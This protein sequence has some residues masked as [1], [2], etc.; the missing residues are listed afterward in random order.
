MDVI[1]TPVASATP[2][3]ATL[4]QARKQYVSVVGSE[5]GAGKIYAQFLINEFGIEWIEAKHDAPGAE[6]DKFRAERGL[7]YTD[8]KAVGHTN[9][10]VKLKQIKDHARNILKAL[11][12]PAEGESAEGES[13][14]GESTGKRENRSVQVR[15]I[16]EL[17][18]LYKFCKK[19]VLNEQQANAFRSIKQA[20]IDLGV[21]TDNIA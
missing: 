10:S 8:L 12:K 9:P 6:M 4:E 20:L 13:A 5:Y 16:E 11:E 1:V 14:E 3:P 2:A 17:M 18:D 7:F 21:N 19:Q 15:M